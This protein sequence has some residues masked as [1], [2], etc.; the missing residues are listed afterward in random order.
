MDDAH[1]GPPRAPG[2]LRPAEAGSAAYLAV[3][4]GGIVPATAAGCEIR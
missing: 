1:T 4:A 2:L 3:F